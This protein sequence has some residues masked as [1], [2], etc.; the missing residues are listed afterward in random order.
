MTLLDKIKSIN[1]GILELN[2]II[3]QNLLF[4]DTF[5]KVS[6]ITLILNS[7]IMPYLPKDLMTK[8]YLTDSKQKA[9]FDISIS[10]LFFYV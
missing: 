2:V 3:T 10:F 6:S 8:F 1:R 4:G 7:K 9:V 5:L